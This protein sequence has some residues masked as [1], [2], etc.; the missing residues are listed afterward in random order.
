MP[1]TGLRK[2]L[3][4]AAHL[5]D[6]SKSAATLLSFATDDLENTI[7]A[8]WA[9]EGVLMLPWRPRI[10]RYTRQTRYHL[11]GDGLVFHHGEH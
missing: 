11:G 4:A 6:H 5:F 8:T 9:L 10:P 3:S 2:Y 1:V 7:T